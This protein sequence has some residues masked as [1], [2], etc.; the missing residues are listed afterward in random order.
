MKYLMTMALAAACYLSATYASYNYEETLAWEKAAE[1]YLNVSD[2]EIFDLK[3][4]GNQVTFTY[5]KEFYNPF[6]VATFECTGTGMSFGG[7]AMFQTLECVEKEP[8]LWDEF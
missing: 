6:V 2:I 7:Q 8:T 5:D 1:Q 4:V 3:V